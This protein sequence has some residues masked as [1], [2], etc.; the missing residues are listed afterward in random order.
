MKYKLKRFS[1]TILKDFP[2]E[3]VY[4]FIN[5][6]GTELYDECKEKSVND[7]NSSNIKKGKFNK[8]E[9]E[10]YIK[11]STITFRL[12]DRTY[13]ASDFLGIYDGKEKLDKEYDVLVNISDG[14]IVPENGDL[15][16]A[17]LGILPK[18]HTKNSTWEYKFVKSRGSSPKPILTIPTKKEEIE[19]IVKVFCELAVF[20]KIFSGCYYKF[21]FTNTNNKQRLFSESF[22]IGKTLI[23]YIPTL[24]NTSYFIFGHDL[25]VDRLSKKI[26]EL[27]K[28]EFSKDKFNRF[29]DYC[30]KI[31]KG[32]IYFVNL[33]PV[34]CYLDT[35]LLSKENIKELEK[36]G[37][38]K[39]LRTMVDWVIKAY[40][41]NKHIIFYSDIDSPVVFAHEFGHYLEAIDGTLGKI[42]A[43]SNKGIFSSGFAGFM[44]F[45]LGLTGSIGE[46]IG[47]LSA[48]LLRSP[49]LLSE[50]M[51]SYK[52]LEV[53]KESKIFTE[54]E[55]EHT[56]KYF[57]AAWNSYLSG[58]YNVAT[59]SSGGRWARLAWKSHKMLKNLE[60]K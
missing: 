44:A 45:L 29:L 23:S 51:A 12:N 13:K 32:N 48:M 30:K 37:D 16:I 34:S 42:Q 39:R 17:M 27:S 4:K 10:K 31:S 1:N 47:T 59:I 57:K 7:I 43:K 5:C 2:Q 14:F 20:L 41:E 60:K 3:E 19:D 36:E 52:G 40:N 6:R 26:N 21:Y 46:I 8:A 15:Y 38:P 49:L 54:E 33:G 56:K 25:V 9:L 22:S 11:N 55:L 50:Y 18:Y 24:I 58:A 35:K 28:R 53:M